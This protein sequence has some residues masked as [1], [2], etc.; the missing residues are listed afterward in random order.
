MSIRS[1]HVY[2]E[3]GRF[4]R[5]AGDGKLQ[6]TNAF[7]GSPCVTYANIPLAKASQGANPDAVG[8]KIDSIFECKDL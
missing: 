4:S 1:G 6:H 7:E 5:K 8:R 2:I 3:A